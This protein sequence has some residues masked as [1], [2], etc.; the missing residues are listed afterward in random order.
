MKAFRTLSSNYSW[1]LDELDWPVTS[2]VGPGLSGVIASATRVSWLDPS[3]GTLEYRGVPIERLAGMHSYE[4][5]A[6]LLITGNEPADDEAAFSTFRD[7]LR[8]SRELPEDV[9]ALIRAMDP[10]IHPTRMLRAGVS[11][12]GCHEMTV[13]D[14]LSGDRHWREL[15]IIAQIAALVAQIAAHR[16]GR[17]PVLFHANYDI[18]HEMLR[19]LQDRDPDPEDVHSLDLLWVLFADHGLDAPTF[20]SMVVASTLADPYYNVVAGLSALRGDKLGGA[21]ETVLEQ[22]L[23]LEDPEAARLWVAS[24]IASGGRI[25]GFGHR[26]Y[27]MPDPRVVILRKEVAAQARRKGT[28]ELFDIARAVEDEA[29]RQLAPRGVHVN[30]NFYAALLFHL[31]GADK[32]MLPCLYMVGR[33]AGLMARVHEELENPRLYRP[34]DRYVGHPIRRITRGAEK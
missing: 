16:T 22:I 13:E 12:L 10:G 1:A 27:H 24:T 21:G 6:H 31:I 32:P 7:N 2:E 18:A 8:A 20:T 25:G 4:E 3:S 5:I 34:L 30:I 33:M 9:I 28:P 29:L 23:G 11:A 14:D 17:G 15:R 26:L 19:A